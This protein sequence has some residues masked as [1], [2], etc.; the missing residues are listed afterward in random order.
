MTRGKK[1]YSIDTWLL[2]LQPPQ[3]SPLKEKKRK[4]KITFFAKK[5][6][7]RHFS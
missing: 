1:F 4:E 3:H 6:Y 7:F 2:L 5:K